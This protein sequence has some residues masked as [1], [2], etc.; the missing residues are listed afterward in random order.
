MYGSQELAFSIRALLAIL[1]VA[2]HLFFVMRTP[3]RSFFSLSI[4]VLY[5]KQKVYASI[6]NVFA[7]ACTIAACWVV[8]ASLIFPTKTMFFVE[9][10]LE[11]CHLV[12]SGLDSQLNSSLEIPIFTTW[13]SLFGGVIRN[14]LFAF[15]LILTLKTCFAVHASLTPESRFPALRKIGNHK[16]NFSLIAR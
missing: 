6:V 3:A 7:I 12:W 2:A 15:C 13:I 5:E 1:N 4:F 10:V 11:P 9:L 8:F 14:P 16:Y